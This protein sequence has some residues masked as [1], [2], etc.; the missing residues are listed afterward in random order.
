MKPKVS[1]LKDDPKSGIFLRK[2]ITFGLAKQHITEICIYKVM[3]G[4]R[5][6]VSRY[7]KGEYPT[8]YDLDLCA[9]AVPEFIALIY[10]IVYYIVN[11]H[12]RDLKLGESPKDYSNFI[13]NFT[14]KPIW[15][16]YKFEEFLEIAVKMDIPSEE[17]VKINDDTLT[18]WNMKYRKYNNR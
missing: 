1:I 2:E 10:N 17:L 15:K 6:R 13:P 8:L 11:K 3:H 7:Q 12:I 16:D 14:I 9:G 5:I 4:W 18:E